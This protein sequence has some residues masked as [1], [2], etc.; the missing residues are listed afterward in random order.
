MLWRKTTLLGVGLLGGSLGLAMKRARLSE[1]ICGFVRRPESIDEC[2]QLG[3][4]DQCGCDLHTAVENADLL[5]LC[6]P[7]GKMRDLLLAAIP[8]IKPGALITDV[9]SVK[10]SVARELE[11]LAVQAGAT[12]IG[13]HPM[14]GSERMGVNASKIDLF[15]KAISV[16]TPTVSSPKSKV[17]ALVELWEGVGAR[18][19]VMSPE[20][21][22]ELVSRSSHLP[23]VVAAELANY[24]LSPAHPKEQA[25]LCAT[26]FRDTT[27]VASG[28]PEMWRDIALANSKNL[29]RVLRAFIEHLEEFKA[30]LEDQDDKKIT[31]FF[32]TAKQRRD[33]WCAP[34]ASPS[35]E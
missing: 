29:A 26:G 12:F 30:A 17:Q 19:L 18:P 9:G 28:S 21:H 34:K 10:A 32:E 23:H 24:V 33:K 6:T 2:L 14:A 7:I 3:V 15:S 4:V 27:R 16:V 35:P 25:M 11:P 5:I 22:D 8:S 13:S 31:E 1:Q 20:Q